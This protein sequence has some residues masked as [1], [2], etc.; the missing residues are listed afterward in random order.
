MRRSTLLCPLSRREHKTK[1]TT[2]KIK[3]KLVQTS[4]HSTGNTSEID[5]LCA[6]YALCTSSLF[7][8]VMQHFT[9]FL[10]SFASPVSPIHSKKQTAIPHTNAPFW[11]RVKHS[12]TN[13]RAEH[14]TVHR[15]AFCNCATQHSHEMMVRQI[16]TRKKAR[17]LCVKETSSGAIAGAHVCDYFL[18]FWSTRW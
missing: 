14:G 16:L 3:I 12:R 9:L 11:I 13:S 2:K 7:P 6:V 8:S 5:Q 4:L 1:T 15:K 18:D 10:V 17:N